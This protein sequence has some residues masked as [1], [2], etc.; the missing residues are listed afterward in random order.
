MDAF[1]ICGRACTQ[2]DARRCALAHSTARRTGDAAIALDSAIREEHINA[3]SDHTNPISL[4]SA[5][6]EILLFEHNGTVTS[7]SALAVN[8]ADLP[9]WEMLEAAL[10]GT[11][12]SWQ[13]LD[14][15]GVGQA[16]RQVC[17]CY[18]VGE[19]SIRCAINAGHS[20]LAKLKSVLRRG[21]NCG[22]CVPELNRLL[23]ASIDGQPTF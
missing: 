21:T 3:T 14:G 19:R 2:C 10:A 15:R 4:T 7:A 22:S 8:R 9:A 20:S 16:D 5:A 6:L 11:T 18:E 13:L 23:A 1:P 12:P 17:T